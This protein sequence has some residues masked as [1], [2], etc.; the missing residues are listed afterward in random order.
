MNENIRVDLSAWGARELIIAADILTAYA[1]AGST[2]AGTAYNYLPESWYDD[3]VHLEFNP[4]S[5]CVFLT[6]SDCQVLVLGDGGLVGFYSTP[7]DGHEGT[8]DELRDAYD[9]DWHDEDKQYLLDILESDA[10][11]G[12]DWE[13]FTEQ[14]RADVRGEDEDEDETGSEEDA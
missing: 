6:N 8:L 13:A 10:P 1:H 5:G 12:D 14:V 11:A 9:A 4:Y 3:G 7:Y 2:Y